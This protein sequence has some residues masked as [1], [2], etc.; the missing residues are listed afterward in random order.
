MGNYEEETRLRIR[1]PKINNKGAKNDISIRSALRETSD[2]ELF[3][4][5]ESVIANPE[6]SLENR[7]RKV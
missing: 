2:V 3:K 1:R 5:G 6:P 4:F 7:S